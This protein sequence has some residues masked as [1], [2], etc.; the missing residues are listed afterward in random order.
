MLKHNSTKSLNM[1]DLGTIKK[2]VRMEIL[3]DRN[4]SRLYSSLKRYIKKVLHTS[5]NMMS[6]KVMGIPLVV[7]FK[8]SSTLCPRSVEDIDYMS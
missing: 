6:A 5:F 3:R 8:M 7:H 2:I 1:K 4:A